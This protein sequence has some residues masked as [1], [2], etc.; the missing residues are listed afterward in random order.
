MEWGWVYHRHSIFAVVRKIKSNHR[1]VSHLG[2]VAPKN[3]KISVSEDT[4]GTLAHL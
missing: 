2:Q 4:T 1:D 3:K